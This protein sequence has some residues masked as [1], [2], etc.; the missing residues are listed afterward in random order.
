MT[1]IVQKSVTMQFE[2][3]MSVHLPFISS[4][5]FTLSATKYSPEQMLSTVT[6]YAIICTFCEN[7]VCNRIWFGKQPAATQS[8][9]AGSFV[10]QFA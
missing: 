10:F 3:I 7:C 8:M 4:S 2:C 1:M 6:S 5:L 9:I